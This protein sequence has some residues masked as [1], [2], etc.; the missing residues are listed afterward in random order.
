MFGARSST[1]TRLGKD[2]WLRAGPRAWRVADTEGEGYA[3]PREF[4]VLGEPGGDQRRRA[5]DP[6]GH[7]GAR[8]STPP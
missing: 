3:A 2:P 1:I 6:C 7:M 4:Q 5:R 8:G